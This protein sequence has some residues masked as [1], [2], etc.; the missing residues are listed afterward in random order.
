[1]FFD[2]SLDLRCLVVRC[3]VDEENYSLEFM[4][5]SVCDDVVQV[6]SEFDIS[7]TRKAIPHYFLLWPEE[8]DETVYSLGITECRNI[9]STTFCCPTALDFWKQFNPFFILEGYCNPFF[10]RAPAARLYRCISALL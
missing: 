10:K 7:S 2:V 9:E 5:F 8:R 4:S 1:M 3:F 6:F